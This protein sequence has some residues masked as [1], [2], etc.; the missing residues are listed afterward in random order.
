MIMQNSLYKN[1]ADLFAEIMNMY[2]LIYLS[3]LSQMLDALSPHFERNLQVD[4]SVN[5]QK[6]CRVRYCSKIENSDYFAEVNMSLL[7]SFSQ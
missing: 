3:A 7:G 6:F 4:F 1:K 5:F 2:S